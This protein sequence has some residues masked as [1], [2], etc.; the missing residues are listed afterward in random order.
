MYRAKGELDY[1]AK[2]FEIKEPGPG[3]V[4]IKVEAAPLNPSDLYM[5]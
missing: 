3:E 5:M 4:L 2:L 1:S